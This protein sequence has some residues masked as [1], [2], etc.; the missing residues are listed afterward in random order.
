[1]CFR[2]W[3]VYCSLIMNSSSSK[4][5]G[6]SDSLFSGSTTGTMTSID[7]LD[8]QIK[9]S[10]ASL[11]A[12]MGAIAE[13]GASSICSQDN[14]AELGIDS[15]EKQIELLAIYSLAGSATELAD[16][17]V[18]TEF[19]DEE[20]RFSKEKSICFQILGLM[21]YHF[22]LPFDHP[23]F[24][25]KN[26][27]YLLS[28]TTFILGT[29]LDVVV[30]SIETRSFAKLKNLF[31]IIFVL[32]LF[33]HSMLKQTFL[34]FSVDHNVHNL[35]LL[36]DSSTPDGSLFDILFCIRK[37][38]SLEDSGMT[39][40]I[41]DA[42]CKMLFRSAL[43]LGYII[44]LIE[45]PSAENVRELATVYHEGGSQAEL[46][47]VA[48]QHNPGFFD[49]VT[50]LMDFSQ[51]DQSI[52]KDFIAR[53]SWDMSMVMNPP[54][55]HLDPFAQSVLQISSTTFL[56]LID[57]FNQNFKLDLSK[58]KSLICYLQL[59]LATLDRY[60]TNTGNLLDVYSVLGDMGCQFSLHALLDTCLFILAFALN[61]SD[62]NS[63]EFVPINCVSCFA[64][65]YVPPVRRENFVFQS[66]PG[67]SSLLKCVLLIAS[68]RQSTYSILYRGY[69]VIPAMK[70]F[71]LGDSIEYKVRFSVVE[72]SF[73]SSLSI[74]I[75]AHNMHYQ[76]SEL[77]SILS[78]YVCDQFT[79][80]VGIYHEFGIVSLLH[81]LTNYGKCEMRVVTDLAGILS[82]MIP[83]TLK[84]PP[85]AQIVGNVL[86]GSTIG[87]NM[88][89]LFVEALDDGNTLSFKR[90]IRYLRCHPSSL[91][92]NKQTKGTVVL[93]P[94]DY[95]HVLKGVY[96][97]D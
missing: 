59:S 12:K 14:L 73:Y 52:C 3:S 9:L 94:S 4:S 44:P 60:L 62:F 43:Q 95:I 69:S 40:P 42:A 76:H 80:L 64:F 11:T 85:K 5:P 97:K 7:L 91:K 37:R 38:M 53:V 75:L 39:I 51:T 25:F 19:E 32:H 88:L 74:L 54:I 58:E 86:S 70:S 65:D 90:L 16:V 57:L 78:S 87:R 49:A 46:V 66:A 17:M 26:Y 83:V 34:F 84:D 89:R 33:N 79:S 63:S 1:M 45:Y 31:A 92:A 2:S 41:G 72:L 47:V 35:T 30:S 68:C 8:D 20:A 50:D 48:I 28:N 96:N 29:V 81:L 61:K 18:S 71:G 6:S 67:S 23:S 82:A 93:D 27:G 77:S 24:G 36:E 55:E 13:E 10:E 22:Q 56:P 21:L 15:P